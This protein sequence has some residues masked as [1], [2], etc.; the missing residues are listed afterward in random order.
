MVKD[1]QFDASNIAEKYQTPAVNGDNSTKPSYVGLKIKQEN[2]PKRGTSAYYVNCLSS[3]NPLDY[4]LLSTVPRE[5]EFILCKLNN[6]RADQ[7]M[8]SP[9]KDSADTKASKK[10]LIAPV[11]DNSGT[12]EARRTTVVAKVEEVDGEDLVLH[13]IGECLCVLDL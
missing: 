7:R 1:K 9:H 11:S 12:S 10:G 5:N 4:P 6:W 13:V 8:N 3:L 2:I